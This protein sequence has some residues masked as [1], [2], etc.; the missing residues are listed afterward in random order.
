MCPPHNQRFSNTFNESHFDAWINTALCC[1]VSFHQHRV[2]NS[3]VCHDCYPTESSR[4]GNLYDH[5][6]RHYIHIGHGE[7]FE[8]CRVCDC[9][10]PRNRLTNGCLV[11]RVALND[12]KEYLRRSRDRPFDSAE[13][14]IIAISEDRSW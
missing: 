9:I 4:V 14:T 2:N 6:S 11:C 1:T 5:V 12:F 10:L 8:T 3:I 7:L 13:P